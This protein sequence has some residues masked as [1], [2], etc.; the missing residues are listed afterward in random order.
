MQNTQPPAKKQR[1]EEGLGKAT[2]AGDNTD[3]TMKKKKQSNKK[4]KTKEVGRIAE[5]RQFLLKNYRGALQEYLQ[6]QGDFKLSF[7]TE[8]KDES[9]TKLPKIYI[10]T[11]N[12]ND[13]VGTGEATTKKQAVHLAALAVI[14]ELKLITAREYRSITKAAREAIQVKKTK[15]APTSKVVVAKKTKEELLKE[16][17]IDEEETIYTGTVKFYLS[18]QDYGFIS[19][20]EDIE[21]KGL[22]AK[23]R[24]YV[25]K[26]DIVCCSEEV[27]LNK[28]SK[29]I[30]KLYK[31]SMGIGAY[32]V[33]NEDGTPIIFERK[34]GDAGK[35][36]KAKRKKEPTS[37]PNE[38]EHQ[39]TSLHWGNTDSS[40]ELSETKSEPKNEV[41]H[42]GISSHWGIRDWS[43]ELSEEWE[44]EEEYSREEK[45]TVWYCAYGSNMSRDRI[46][47]RISS[48][49]IMDEPVAVQFMDKQL[50]FNKLSSGQ[51]G[52]ANLENKCRGPR[53]EAVL[54]PLTHYAIGLLDGF[55]GVPYHYQR[56]T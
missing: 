5:S 54:W 15:K 18:N 51:A 33:Q 41:E 2:S 48:H 10:S 8:Q 7:D 22:T 45:G 31:D 13:V 12:A 4:K 32:E 55:E 11:C 30:F 27:G 39:G 25:S 28:N 43:G 1:T 37:G 29:V 26:D 19:I 21:F 53:A 14:K 56:E 44:E 50:V 52:F 49:Q 6:K 20:D 42:Q 34:I 23:G 24:I 38:D 3:P 17:E 9:N 36:V 40:G 46:T 47:R 16:R 35:A